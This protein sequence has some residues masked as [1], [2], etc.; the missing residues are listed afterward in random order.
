[1]PC[2]QESVRVTML[3]TFGW[4]ARFD[5]TFALGR[6]VISCGRVVL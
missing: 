6:A 5:A 3:F 2:F 1:M 4:A